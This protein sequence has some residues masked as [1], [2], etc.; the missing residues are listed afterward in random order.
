MS[1]WRAKH[2]SWSVT[3]PGATITWAIVVL[4]EALL[5]LL[6]AWSLSRLG[7][8]ALADPGAQAAMKRILGFTESSPALRHSGVDPSEL[9]G[10]AKK[11]G[12]D[13]APRA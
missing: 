6:A 4:N 11:P 8:S 13:D 7:S 3:S 12:T 10:D 9:I 2:S 1:V 5:L